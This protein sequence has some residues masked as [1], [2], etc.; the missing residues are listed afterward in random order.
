[1]SEESLE[2]DLR[3]DISAKTGS[4][5]GKV[6]CPGDLEGKAGVVMTCTLV[7]QGRTVEVAVNVTGLDGDT[8]KFDYE[9]KDPAAK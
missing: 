7:H 6:D 4:S 3:K 8:V 2:K 9:T 5:V 1:M